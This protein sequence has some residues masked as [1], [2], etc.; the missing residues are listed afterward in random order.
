MD[1]EDGLQKFLLKNESGEWV[2]LKC[3]WLIAQEIYMSD[4]CI[5]VH[6]VPR[7]PR[8]SAQWSLEGAREKLYTFLR[9]LGHLAMEEDLVRP[10]AGVASEDDFKKFGTAAL[11]GV[12]QWGA[13]QEWHRGSFT[14]YLERNDEEVKKRLADLLDPTPEIIDRY[15]PQEAKDTEYY[16]KHIR[17]KSKQVE[18]EGRNIGLYNSLMNSL[19]SLALAKGK[20][21]ALKKWIDG[22]L[23]AADEIGE[24]VL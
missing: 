3:T 2:R 21:S 24:S 16:L 18:T 15:K 5:A 9:W 8:D 4:I 20:S 10:V 23:N 1:K 11:N 6:L 19:G 14:F 7:Q 13:D 17:E 22:V 12:K